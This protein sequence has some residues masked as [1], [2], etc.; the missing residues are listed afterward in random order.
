LKVLA[1]AADGTIDYPSI[2]IFRIAGNLL[3]DR[4]RSASRRRRANI[5]DLAPVSAISLEF[6]EDQTPP[7]L[8]ASTR[9]FSMRSG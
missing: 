4:Y 5:L 7:A 8:S 1:V 3:K 6:V 9:A 2:L